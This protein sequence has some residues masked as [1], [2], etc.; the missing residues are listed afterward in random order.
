MQ[1]RRQACRPRRKLEP[2]NELFELTAHLL[3]KCFS[4]EQIAGKLRSMEFP[5][6]EDAYVCRETIYSA[7]MDSPRFASDLPCRR[8]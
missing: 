8:T 4:P 3:R 6:F 1:A 5:Q 7:Y 2:C